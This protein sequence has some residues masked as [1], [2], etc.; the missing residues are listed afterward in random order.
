M[1]KAGRAGAKRTCAGFERTAS[2]LAVPTTVQIRRC[3]TTCA[4][5][6]MRSNVPNPVRRSA[7]DGATRRAATCNLADPQ[8]QPMLPPAP[9]R[10]R[11][12]ACGCTVPS[13]AL[14]HPQQRAPLW[15]LTMNAMLIIMV[16]MAVSSSA[17]A[18]EKRRKGVT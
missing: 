7:C 9:V 3:K 15:P 2:R 14:S 5:D 8:P 10:V 18:K 1:V 16:G 17:R 11:L 4:C 6:G 12:D 13:P